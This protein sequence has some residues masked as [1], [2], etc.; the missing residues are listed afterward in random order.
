[1]TYDVE[2]PT[3]D[4][5][6]DHLSRLES[7]WGELHRIQD[8]CHSI[9]QLALEVNVPKGFKVVYP[10]TG[11][12]AVEVAADHVAG[13]GPLIRVPVV[14]ETDDLRKRSEK[15]EKWLQAA[16]HRFEEQETMPLTRAVVIDLGWA[17]MAVTKGPLFDPETWSPDPR[18]SATSMS[19]EELKDA[20]EQYEI[21]K[22]QQWP[23]IWEVVDPRYVFPDPGTHG[24]KYVVVSYTRNVGE[25]RA[26]WKSWKGIRPGGTE[27]YKDTD[28]VPFVEWWDCKY[29]VYMVN[30]E[31]LEIAEHKYGKPP[32]QI[33]SSGLGR[34]SGKPEQRYR[35]LIWSAAGM[36]EQEI[37]VACQLDA[38]M[39]NAAWTQ[40]L[41]PIGSNFKQLVPGTTV[42]MKPEDIDK[43]KPVTELR[44]EVVQALLQEHQWV[45]TKIEDATYPRVVG[46]QPV[47][48]VASG[49]GQN[50]LAALGK[51][52]FGAMAKQTASL[53]AEGYSDLLHCVEKVVEESV[54]AYGDTKHGFVQ[55][56]IG[57]DDIKG[58]RYVD[59][60][61][62]P[63]LITDR[64]NEIATGSQLYDRGLLDDDTMLE[65]YGGQEQPEEIRVKI[66]RDRILKSPFVQGIMQLAA[67][68][69]LGLID[70]LNEKAEKLGL[71]PAAIFQ[72][73]MQSLVPGMGGGAGAG[74]G[75]GL[76]GEAGGVNGAGAG[77]PDSAMFPTAQTQPIPGG[78]S[79]MSIPTQ[80]GAA[81]AAGVPTPGRSR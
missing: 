33:R 24:K 77:T 79:D 2:Q 36:I 64:A 17:G 41:T 71:P 11:N 59:V 37:Y 25:I 44:G 80:T 51:L 30:R 15:L 20:I 14:K 70:W 66:A 61:L 53:L 50:S 13:D 23:F 73:L 35:P 49:Y 72:S 1:M 19:K 58:Y 39:R 67:A 40:M 8:A 3:A 34:R 38:V 54:P 69:E 32:F 52:R 81:K 16:H 75:A 26:Q 22:E 7:Y 31:I 12:T 45:Q 57:P 5:I 27:E 46:G 4:S 6:K 21:E 28:E 63:S 10:G 47:P 48:Q 60:I 42:R 76:L 43:T 55:A 65:D 56:T 74:A 18:L 78:P 29:K 68:E 9:Y 62:N